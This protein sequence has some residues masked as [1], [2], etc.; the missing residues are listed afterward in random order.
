MTDDITEATFQA[1]VIELAHLLGWRTN[2]V[3][4]SI[5]RGNRWTTATSVV[6]FPDLLCWHEKQHRVLAV[7]LKSATGKPTAEQ[8]A[9]LASLAAAGIE[10]YLWRPSDWPTIERTLSPRRETRAA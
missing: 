8:T 4:R 5:G 1:Q 3:R 2:H 9:V 6:G 10:T 7:E